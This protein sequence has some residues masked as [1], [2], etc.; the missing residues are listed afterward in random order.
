L[1]QAR[2]ASEALGVELWECRN[3]ERNSLQ[4][5]APPRTSLL[6]QLLMSRDTMTERAVHRI[7][8]MERAIGPELELRKAGGEKKR[9]NFKAFQA[10]ELLSGPVADAEAHQKAATPWHP[11]ECGGG[12]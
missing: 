9:L 12:L 10:R 3:G 1:G 7:S 6:P 8:T 2:L 4:R 11:G 5:G